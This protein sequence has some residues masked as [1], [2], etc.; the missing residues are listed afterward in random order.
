MKKNFKIL[1]VNP[2][3][4]D[5]SLYDFWIKPLGLLV[6]GSILKREG[7][8]VFLL[9]FLDRHN[10]FF[11]EKLGEKD[12]KK[13]KDKS[14]STGKFPSK[15]IEKP[16][17][18]KDIKRKYKIYGWYEDILRDYL[19]NFDNFDYILITSGMTYWYPGI[20]KTIDF[21]KEFYPQSI[22]ILGGRYVF[23]CREH[24][25]K[26]FYDTI[27]IYERK[28]KNILEKLSKIMDVEIDIEKYLK[29]DNICFD[30][31]FDYPILKHFAILRS[32][33]C[34]FSCSY[35]VSNL[36]FPEFYE[37]GDEKIIDEIERINKIK[38]A[39][40]L[41]F[42]DDALLYPK[43]KFKN[44]LKKLIEKNLDI[45]IHTPN[46]IHARYIDEEMAYLLKKANFKTIRIGFETIN[47]KKLEKNWSKKL[48]LKHFEDAITN[49]SKAGFDEI[50]AYILIG[51]E[52]DDFD[53][54]MK[55]YEYLYNKKIKIYPA[56]F[57]PVPST[58][59]FD[60]DTDPLLSNKSLYFKGNKDIGFEL[61]EKIK[62]FAKILNKNIKE[63]FSF[64]ELMKKFFNKKF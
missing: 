64:K 1:L 18:L 9:D 32:F 52:E 6:L 20:R 35:C 39:K 61:Y 10:P 25:E 50:G 34:P 57:S 14:F 54:I 3:V 31:Y 62:D 28:I 53:E 40:D 29:R 30:I 46:A 2:W 19:K 26:N 15:E 58:N 55:S 36:L 12:L 17:L 33:G 27:I 51:T 47:E 48:T 8:K 11:R 59:F 38:G 63:N 42:Y 24:A 56:Q 45:R 21:L 44:F 60:K 13:I 7:F 41:A 5:F 4:T 16:S 37:L 49:L 22:Y 43:E 23:L